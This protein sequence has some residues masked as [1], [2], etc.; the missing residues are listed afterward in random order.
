MSLEKGIE[1][2]PNRSAVIDHDDHHAADYW[3]TRVI[4]EYVR[5]LIWT[6]LQIM[7]ESIHGN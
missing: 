2:M 3:R 1:A 6:T 4:L 5:L 7:W